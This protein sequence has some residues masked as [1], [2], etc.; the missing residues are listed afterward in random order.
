MFGYFN[1]DQ[2]NITISYQILEVNYENPCYFT[3][4]FKN[5]GHEIEEESNSIQYDGPLDKLESNYQE[6]FDDIM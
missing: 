1:Y 4:K 5:S 3:I 2:F 6:Q